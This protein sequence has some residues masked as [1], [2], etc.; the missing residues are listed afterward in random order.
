MI[1]VFLTI[2]YVCLNIYLS[3]VAFKGGVHLAYYRFLKRMTRLNDA[4]SKT[5]D[6]LVLIE[7]EYFLRNMSAKNEKISFM[8]WLKHG[9]LGKD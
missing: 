5:E 6:P 2:L 7:Y 9:F 4:I 1:T 8:D 3:M